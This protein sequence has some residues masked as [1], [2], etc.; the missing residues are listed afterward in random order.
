MTAKELRTHLQNGG[1]IVKSRDDH[2]PVFLSR[3]EDS[4][5][6][7]SFTLPTHSQCSWAKPEAPIGAG[8]LRPRIEPWLTALVQSEHLSLLIGSGLT[9][10]VH[11]L[12]TEAAMPGMNV[13]TF[14][15]PGRR[16]SWRNPFL[17]RILH[18]KLALLPRV[19]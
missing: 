19:L 6:T 10:A 7:D 3:I 14:E 17:P 15:T 18:E 11:R 2:A 1:Q 5:A 8:Q 13:A 16:Q 4:T 9:H 12:G